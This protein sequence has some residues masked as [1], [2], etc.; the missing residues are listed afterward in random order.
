MSKNENIKNSIK[1]TRQRKQNMNCK[2]FELKIDYSH[3]SKQQK[4]YLKRLFLEK[5]RLRNTLLANFDRA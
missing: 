5:K 1:E 3:L 4:E 2:V